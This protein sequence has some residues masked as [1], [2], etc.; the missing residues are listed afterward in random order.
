MSAEI[1]PVS[2]LLHAWSRGAKEALEDLVPLLY[3]ELHRIAERQFAG[4]RADHTLQPSALVNELYLRFEK[5]EDVDWRDREHFLAIAATEMRR[6]LI[7][8]ARKKGAAKR[9]FG[10]T[11]V[12]LTEI[13]EPTAEP[14]ERWA[15]LLAVDEA[16]TR[17]QAM[18]PEACRIVELRFFGGLSMPEV[19]RVLGV[20]ERTVYRRWAAARAWLYSQLSEPGAGDGGSVAPKG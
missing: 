13:A 1:S 2:E 10:A 8:H 20:T 14:G 7:V 3:P 16:L 18:D 5:R 11:R 15:D 12:F 9:G 17:L 19:A 6:I 4:Q